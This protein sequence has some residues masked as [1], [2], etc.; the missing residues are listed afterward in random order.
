M[1]ERKRTGPFGTLGAW[2]RIWTPPRDVEVPPPPR[3]L[4]LAA[5]AAALVGVG[6]VFALVVLPAI[7]DARERTAA[8]DRRE[9]AVAKEK[10]ERKL[11]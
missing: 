6:L 11:A 10:A 8:A 4:T 5:I 1:S 9:A 2:L 7:D 3:P